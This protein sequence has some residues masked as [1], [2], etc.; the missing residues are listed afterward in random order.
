MGPWVGPY[1]MLLLF[2]RL[3]ATNAVYT[4]LFSLTQLSMSSLL[5][6]TYN[7]LIGCFF[8]LVFV[9]HMLRVSSRH[10]FIASERDKSEV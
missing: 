5:S 9:L 8:P 3:G 2:G 10:A 6:D 1:V 7:I 4:A